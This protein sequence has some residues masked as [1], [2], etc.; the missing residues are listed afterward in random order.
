MTI[1]TAHIP[2]LRVRTVDEC[3]GHESDYVVVSLVRASNGQESIQS[4]SPMGFLSVPNRVNVM[5]SR[6]KLMVFMVGDLQYFSESHIEYWQKI[7][8]SCEIV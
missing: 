2:G 1:A 8:A 7:V 4:S 6:G 5:L 3:Q